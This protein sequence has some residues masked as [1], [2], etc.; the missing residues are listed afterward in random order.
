MNLRTFFILFVSTLCFCG[1]IAEA[2]DPVITTA[3]AKNHIGETV[4][5]KGLVAQVTKGPKAVFLNFGAAYPNSEFTAVSFNL[6]FSALS[7]F[8]GKTVTI[9][10]TITGSNGKPGITVS[11]LGQISAVP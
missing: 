9:S 10:G 8:Q 7:G 6:P 11:N 1:G 4:V 5:V 3:E 2:A